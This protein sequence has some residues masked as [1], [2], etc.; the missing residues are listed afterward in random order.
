MS[1]LRTYMNIINKSI[2][3]LEA[4][5]YKLLNDMTDR[6]DTTGNPEGQYQPGSQDLVLLNKPGISNLKEIE[7]IEFDHLIQFQVELFDELTIG[8]TAN[9]K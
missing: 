2:E 6:Y 7:D 4:L 1:L 9:H 3:N 8:S 5:K